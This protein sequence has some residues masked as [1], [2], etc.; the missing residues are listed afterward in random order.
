MTYVDK[1]F[2]KKI[3]VPKNLG[4]KGTVVFIEGYK[5]AQ[6]SLISMFLEKDKKIDRQS[7]RATKKAIANSKWVSYS[8]KW[9]EA[10]AF[11]EC[12]T[13]CKKHGKGVG[14]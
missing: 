10:L 14:K 13:R 12:V 8:R 4:I 11:R 7:K 2:D 9:F 5:Q 6:N 3:S 1:L